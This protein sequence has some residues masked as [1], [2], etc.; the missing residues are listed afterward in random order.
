MGSTLKS[1]ADY[2][3]GFKKY[4]IQ[5]TID[6]G[7]GAPITPGTG[8]WGTAAAYPTVT[9]PVELDR[10]YPPLAAVANVKGFVCAFLDVT[11]SLYQYSDYSGT[12]AGTTNVFTLGIYK[13][14]ASGTQLVTASY[15][16]AA[17]TVAN[18]TYTQV[19]M[20][21]GNGHTQYYLAAGDYLSLCLVAV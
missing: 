7:P 20:R 9:T 4:G 6:L 14:G 18:T 17:T 15:A 16:L 11:L 10:W 21:D 19:D 3:P 2:Y 5:E 8:L 12:P 13:N 1:L